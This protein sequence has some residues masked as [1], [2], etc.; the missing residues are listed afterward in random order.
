MAWILSK[1]LVAS[2]IVGCT[3][4]AQLEDV[5]GCF[6]VKL[7]EEDIKYL[8]ECYVPHN[9]VGALKKGDAIDLKR[10]KK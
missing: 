5:C 8:E 7:S 9:V 3:K 1:P 4:I 2:P 10:F 6:K